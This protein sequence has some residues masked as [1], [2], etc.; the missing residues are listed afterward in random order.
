MFS[1][2][3]GTTARGQGGLA[4]KGRWSKPILP[5]VT[6]YVDS[7]DFPM[8]LQPGPTW[9]ILAPHGTRIRTGEARP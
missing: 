3:A 5:E 9:I 2:I 6:T 1:G 4:A 8:A 7:E